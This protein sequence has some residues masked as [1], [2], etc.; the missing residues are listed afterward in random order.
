[1]EPTAAGPGS[2]DKLDVL[3]ERA[4]AELPLHHPA[5]AQDSGE[6]ASGFGAGL[7]RLSLRV[8]LRLP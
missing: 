4:A 5:D 7:R 6:F 3:R 8:G 2:A 1:M